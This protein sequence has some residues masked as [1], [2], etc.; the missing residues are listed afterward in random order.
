LSAAGAKPTAIAGS[1]SVSDPAASGVSYLTEQLGD[2]MISN[3]Q[4]SLHDWDI[5]LLNNRIGSHAL[6]LLVGRFT[7]RTRVLV[8]ANEE[9]SLRSHHTWESPEQVVCGLQI[10]SH[11]PSWLLDPVY[12]NPAITSLESWPSRAQPMRIPPRMPSGRLWP[13]ISVVTVT[14]NQANFLEDTLRSVLMQGYPNLEYIVLDGQSTDRTP[15]IIARYRNALAYSVSEK[16]EGQSD[17]LNKGF[18]QATGDILTWLNSDDRYLPNTLVR[19]A[20]AF[21]TYE[22]D[23]V[24]GGCG[25]TRNADPAVYRTH[26]S[27]FPVG[28]VE[29]FPA[30]RLLDVDGAWLKG[31]FFWQ[32]EVFWNRR[33]WEKSGSRIAKNLYYCMDYDLWVRMA[34]AGARIVHVP[35]TL[36]IFRFHDAQKTSGE[37][38]PPY[39]PELRRVSSEYLRTLR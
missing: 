22:T 11:P 4:T 9:A 19:V 30:E 39:I 12:K 10:Y 17:A 8:E 23:I 36:A 33:I 26:H 18:A 25:L 37:E 7:P 35:D 24:V 2:W 28:T 16:D 1:E 31:D 34:Q 38:L 21:D 32:P 15:E 20:L 3:H 14:L 27:C 29:R 13:K 6:S 5:L